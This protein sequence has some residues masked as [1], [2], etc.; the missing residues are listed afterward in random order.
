LA[1]L[2]A[3]GGSGRRFV[4]IGSGSTGGN[5]AVLAYEFGWSGLMVDASRK[6]I[7]QL[8]EQ[9]RHNPGVIPVAALVTPDTVNP[10]L[11]THGFTGDVEFMSI[12][13]DSI[14]YWLFDALDACSPRVLVLE[15]NALF[16]SERAVTVPNRP[17]PSGAPKSY[18]GASLA[19]LE[20]LGRTKGYRLVLCEDAG[21]N[22]FFLR[23]D[24]APAIPG[25]A[26]AQAFRHRQDRHDVLGVQRLD[27]D[28]FAHLAGLGLPLVEV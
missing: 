6:A 8:R 10:L 22:A 13:V 26:P 23:R 7:D 5:S 19:A 3:A 15:Y 18:F 2:A 14:D 11:R 9:L 21:V 25:L 28:V 17:K 20:K 24:V 4:E 16:G 1:L 27:G 12:D